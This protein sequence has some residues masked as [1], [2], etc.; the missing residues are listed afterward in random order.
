MQHGHSLPLEL[1]RT[2]LHGA[3]PAVAAM[4]ARHSAP[5]TVSEAEGAETPAA[6]PIGAAGDQEAARNAVWN[7]HSTAPLRPSS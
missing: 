7:A 1:R 2:V 5:P 3:A 4:G 6:A